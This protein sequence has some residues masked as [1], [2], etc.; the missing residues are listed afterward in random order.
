MKA[1]RFTVVGVGAGCSLVEDITGIAP[2]SYGNNGSLSTT[3]TTPVEASL[4]VERQ[5]KVR[6][7]LKRRKNGN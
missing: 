1:G 7:S 4:L 3:P 5:S 2:P 6:R